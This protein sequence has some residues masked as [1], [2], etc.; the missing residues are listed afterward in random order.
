MKAASQCDA[1]L[2]QKEVFS[3]MSERTEKTLKISKIPRLWKW[4][5]ILILLGFWG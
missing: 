4:Y 5:V 1:I 3:R 2:E